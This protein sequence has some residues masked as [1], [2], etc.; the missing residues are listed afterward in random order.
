MPRPAKQGGLVALAQM[1]DACG[2]GTNRMIR[3]RYILIRGLE[4]NTPPRSRGY[5]IPGID[6][7]PPPPPTTESGSCSF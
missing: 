1:G 2:W 5:E 4:L 3:G 6:V 7:L